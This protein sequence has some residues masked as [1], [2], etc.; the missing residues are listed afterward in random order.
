MSGGN[1]FDSAQLE[2]S[3]PISVIHYSQ[4]GQHSAA[5]LNTAVLTPPS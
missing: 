2:G 3:H 4:I 5:R 1:A